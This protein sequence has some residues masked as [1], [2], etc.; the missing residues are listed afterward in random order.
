GPTARAGVECGLDGLSR[1]LANHQSRER[2]YAGGNN[3]SLLGEK[4]LRAIQRCHVQ[5]SFGTTYLCL[6]LFLCLFIHYHRF[7]RARG[8]P[9]ATLDLSPQITENAAG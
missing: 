6:E 3:T 1:S 8:G 9:D 5:S 4:S 2:D 7:R